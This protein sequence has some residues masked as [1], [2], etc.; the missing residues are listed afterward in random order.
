MGWSNRMLTALL[1]GFIL[2][3]WPIAV[4]AQS[5]TTRVVAGTGEAGFEDGSPGKFN[6]PIRLAPYGEGAVLVADI[7]NHAI[8]VVTVDGEVRTIAGAPDRKGFENGPSSSARFASP[9]GV[10]ISREGLIAVVEAENHTV[11]LLRPIYGSDETTPESYDVSTLAGVPGNGGMLDGP[12]AE[13]LFQSPHAVAWTPAGDLLIADIGNARIRRLRSGVVQTA[14]GSGEV[15]GQDGEGG[16]ASFHYPMDV[17]L[18]ENETLWIADAGS[19]S[20]RSLDPEGAVATLR[21]SSAIDTPHGITIGPDGTLYLAEMGTHRV[22]AV[23]REGDVTTL[24][25]TGEA[26]SGPGQLNRPAAVLVHDG[27]VWVAD[28][29]NHRIV[30]CEMPAAASDSEN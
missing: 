8:R 17:A 3:A 25:G 26:G 30:I 14:A 19:H 11:R 7:F 16:A 28:L 2:S 29:D 22:L 27:N 1:M 23:S 24:C 15:G 21:L 18:D 4:G 20:V 5:A 6:K 9:H 12:A 13:A 10:A